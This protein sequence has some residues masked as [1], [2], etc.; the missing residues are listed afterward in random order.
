M[1]FTII[2]G[3]IA[4]TI[5]AFLLGFGVPAD[6]PWCGDANTLEM[7]SRLGMLT[8]MNNGLWETFQQLQARVE[9]D[10]PGRLTEINAKWKTF[11][12][13]LRVSRNEMYGWSEQRN[14]LLLGNGFVIAGK[15]PVKRMTAKEFYDAF[16]KEADK[17][18]ADFRKLRDEFATLVASSLTAGK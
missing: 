12:D 9:K 1:R 16:G 15:G 2:G 13:A 6:N 18:L 17:R 8:G 4:L 5:C 14:L 3:A 11:E 7:D 10:H